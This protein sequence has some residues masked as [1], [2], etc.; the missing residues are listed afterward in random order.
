MDRITAPPIMQ[1]VIYDL[2]R[3]KQSMLNPSVDKVAGP[4]S[5]ASVG[6]MVLFSYSPKHKTT[7]PYYDA[8]PMVFPFSDNGNSF[9]GLNMHYLDPKNRMV[10]FNALLSTANNSQLDDSTKLN[11]NWEI[12]KSLSQHQHMK[13]AIKNYLKDHVRGRYLKVKPEKWTEVVMR[14]D[15]VQWRSEGKKYNIART[16]WHDSRTKINKKK[17][18]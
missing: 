5:E 15:Y 18:R 3:I 11:I 7:L 13:P 6:D 16:A 10:L 8:Y 9:A 12:L 1:G 4:W 2:T 17:A 14:L